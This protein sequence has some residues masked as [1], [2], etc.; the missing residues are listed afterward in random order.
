MTHRAETIMAA[1][2]TAVTGLATTGARVFRGR[3]YAVQP[4]ELPCLLVWADADP[5]EPVQSQDR[6]QSNL[7]VNIDAVVREVSAQVDTRLNLI[8]KEITVALAADYRLGLGFV[9]EI[10]EVGAAEPEIAG[11]GDAAVA[12]MRL[13]WTVKYTRGRTDPAN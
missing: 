6:V 8:R 11:E 10:E 9:H 7:V 12:S 3:A 13:E 5:A 4:A 2:V 1:V